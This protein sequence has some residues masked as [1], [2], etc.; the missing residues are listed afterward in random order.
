MPGWL[1]QTVRHTI[2]A[3]PYLIPWRAWRNPPRR[4]RVFPRRPRPPQ[5]FDRR[6]GASCGR[7]HAR[8]Q[9]SRAGSTRGRAA[10]ARAGGHRPAPGVAAHGG[11]PLRLS[12]PESSGD[13]RD[14]RREARGGAQALLARARRAREATEGEAEMIHEPAEVLTSEQELARQALLALTSAPADPDFR[15]ALRR[16]FVAGSFA[17]RAARGPERLRSPRWFG[18]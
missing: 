2:P 5:R 11:V 13:R 1:P 9:R 18:R 8:R 3:R 7:A 16:E 6:R 10:G 14:D 12:G 15:A 17:P 4:T